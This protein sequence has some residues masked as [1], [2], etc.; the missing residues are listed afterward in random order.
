MA[1][2]RRALIAERTA[3]AVWTGRLSSGSGT[4]RSGT[5]ALS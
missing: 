4:I 3:E 1:I 5:G 2:A